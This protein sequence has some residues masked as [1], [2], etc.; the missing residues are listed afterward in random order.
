MDTKDREGVPV[1]TLDELFE[2]IER[3]ACHA[4]KLLS[5]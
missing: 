4:W 3:Q 1:V 5:A 2:L